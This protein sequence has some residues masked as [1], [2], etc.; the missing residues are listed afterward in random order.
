MTSFALEWTAT[1]LIMSIAF[2]L[3]IEH[4]LSPTICECLILSYACLTM[5]SWK[6]TASVTN[7]SSYSVLVTDSRSC[8]GARVGGARYCYR[9]NAPAR[10]LLIL[11]R[12]RTD[13]I[14]REVEQSQSLCGLHLCS[15][16]CLCT[17]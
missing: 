17:A 4:T 12:L 15:V 10:L 5:Y 7:L 2:G 16:H 8:A 11:C 3:V 13:L 1:I 14:P 9:K 6:S